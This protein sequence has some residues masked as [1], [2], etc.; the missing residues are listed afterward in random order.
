MALLAAV[1]FQGCALESEEYSAINT[2]MFPKTA[3]DAD[4]L[5]TANQRI[6]GA[7]WDGIVMRYWWLELTTDNGDSG[8]SWLEPIRYGN[9]TAGNANGT[10]DGWAWVKYIATLTLTID[11]IRPIDMDET[12]KNR[13]IAETH[14]G[15]GYLAFILYDMFGPI[16]LADLETL[17]NPQVENIIPRATEE[18]MQAFIETN[19]LAAINAPELPYNYKHGDPGY[20]RFTK[21]VA[22][23]LLL[24]HYMQTGQWDKAEA[25]GRELVDNSNYGYGLVPRYKDIFTL[26]NEGHTETIL[27]YPVRREADPDYYN[28]WNYFTVPPTYPVDLEKGGH[29]KLSWWFVDKYHPKDKRLETIL[30]EYEGVDRHHSRA[31]DAQGGDLQYGAIPLKYEID[32]TG[33]GANTYI[34]YIL[35]R[36]ADAIT[37]LSE[38]I[39]RNGNAVTDEAIGLLNRV[40]TRSLPEVPFTAA[41][42]GGS[43]QRFL[44]SL[45]LERGR[46]HYYEDIRRKD[47]IRHGKYEEAIQ[48]KA[49]QLNRQTIIAPH[50]RRFPLPQSAINEG[51]GVIKQNPQ[52]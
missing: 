45:L 6:F 3:A 33:V 5:V 23:M 32:P 8:N 22:H 27:S 17:K 20:G 21:G 10:N 13:L 39:V 37:L 1:A 35:L 11:R 25:E 15:L 12:H 49:A 19:L 18:Q 51:K 24:K 46:E 44:D 50:M 38:A 28:N 2:T 29:L 48:Y 14:C 40:R 43:Q 31:E 7:C 4:A 16:P 47:L 30:T 42:F 36:Y 41:S 9:W 34:D 52:Y 26:A